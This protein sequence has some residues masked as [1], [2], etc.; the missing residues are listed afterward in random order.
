MTQFLFT[1]NKVFFMP[2][3]SL[4][5]GSTVVTT[6]RLMSLF[7]QGHYF[8]WQLLLFTS[9]QLSYKTRQNPNVQKKNKVFFS[10]VTKFMNWMKTSLTLLNTAIKTP[11][12]TAVNLTKAR[13]PRLTWNCGY[14]EALRSLPSRNLVCVEVDEYCKV[15]HCLC[16]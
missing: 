7:I 9:R 14:G 11:I 12:F 15:K 16:R 8:S 6:R 10:Q 5:F 4:F 3:K 1:S 13:G 2:L